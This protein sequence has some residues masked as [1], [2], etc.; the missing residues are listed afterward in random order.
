[1]LFEVKQGLAKLV[2]GWVTAKFIC[3]CVRLVLQVTLA[4]NRE[5]QPWLLSW[6]SSCMDLGL[7]CPNVTVLI[8][9]LTLMTGLCGDLLRPGSLQW[10]Y[11][12][13]EI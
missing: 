8:L 3:Y 13:V 5:P 7:H 1:M 10:L 12:L 4:G 6:V 11:V 9:V 2:F